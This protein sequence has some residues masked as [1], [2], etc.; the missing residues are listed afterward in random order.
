ME[1]KFP[2]L[3][4]L[5]NMKQHQIAMEQFKTLENYWVG[6]DVA[7][8]E[9]MTIPPLCLA[10]GV[11]VIVNKKD[12]P[13]VDINRDSLSFLNWSV[14]SCLAQS[15]VEVKFNSL[16]LT[17][18]MLNEINEGRDVSVPIDIINNVDRPIMLEGDIIRF[19]F[20]N[21]ANRLRNDNLREIINKGIKVEGV[22]GVDW[23]LDEKY[24]DK[25]CLCLKLPLIEKF[26]I[27]QS[28][29]IL[30]V[31]SKDDLPNILKEIPKDFD[32]DFKIGETAK[33]ELSE[34]IM[35][36][37]NTGGYPGGESHGHS[38]LIDPGFKG[39]IRTEIMYGLKYIELLIY[40]K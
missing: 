7:L 29:D 26:Y 25:E 11:K 34:N 13:N 10:T 3:E 1:N 2:K 5:I 37:I 21:D 31:N 19:F 27:P 40:K 8:E 18:T 14:R 24:N 22:E 23:F 39:P 35:A 15:G 16:S 9:R 38:C 20:A 28:N 6:H 17:D 4:D 32:T 12:F 36:V 33:V 30:R